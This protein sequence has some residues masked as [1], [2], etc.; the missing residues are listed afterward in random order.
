MVCSVADVPTAPPG[1]RTP[2]GCSVATVA[3]RK[4]VAPVGRRSPRGAAAGL[5]T[6]RHARSHC[7]VSP[8]AQ[9]LA[10]PAHRAS[11]V[12][13]DQWVG[14]L[15]PVPVVQP[16]GKRSVWVGGRNGSRAQEDDSTAGRLEAERAERRLPPPPRLPPRCR[17]FNVRCGPPLTM[18]AR[19]PAWRKSTKL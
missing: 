14:V 16:S 2:T 11:N 7:R 10:Y 13:A 19:V 17:E 3:Q 8:V 4:A 9:L 5:R 15:G 6:P 18:A 12:T 1:G